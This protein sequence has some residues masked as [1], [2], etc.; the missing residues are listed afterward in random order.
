MMEGSL[1]CR[2]PR[3]SRVVGDMGGTYA[4]M[5]TEESS[6]RE[7]CGIGS[8]DDEDGGDEPQGVVTPN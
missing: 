8:H 7:G 3:L 1:L 2:L 5:E 6:M 4:D